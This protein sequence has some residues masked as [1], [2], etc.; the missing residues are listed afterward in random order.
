MTTVGKMLPEA[1]NLRFYASAI[2]GG[3]GTV[4]AGQ[5][6]YALSEGENREAAGYLGE[7]VLRLFGVTSRMRSLSKKAA[8]TEI[9]PP[10][11]RTLTPVTDQAPPVY[12]RGHPNQPYPVHVV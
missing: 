5:G 3:V 2:E 10:N 1:K 12:R 6:L 9:T 4:R 8:P 7:A 11:V